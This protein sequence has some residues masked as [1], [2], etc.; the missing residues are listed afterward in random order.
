M[1]LVDLFPET[2]RKHQLR[3]HLSQQG[4]PIVGD[5]KYSKNHPLLKGKGLFLSA[6]ELD[7]NHPVNGNRI[8]VKIDQPE[9][10]DA[11][12]ARE[13]NRWKKYKD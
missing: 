13:E 3:I 9:K 10:F 8:N 2:G 6:V 12:L 7:F 11:L 5:K 4:F 1:S